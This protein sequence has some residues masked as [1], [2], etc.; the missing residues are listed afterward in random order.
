MAVYSSNMDYMKDIY[1]LLIENK[2][3]YAFYVFDKEEG[4][5]KF[6][7]D[8]RKKD[9]KFIDWN[10][11][12]VVEEIKPIANEIKTISV[13]RRIN[14]KDVITTHIYIETLKH[15]INVDMFWRDVEKRIV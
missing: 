1:D 3:I 7:I 15:Q 4:F 10:S 5:Y 2:E 11:E 8:S 12:K 6:E 13:E 9:T 14:Y